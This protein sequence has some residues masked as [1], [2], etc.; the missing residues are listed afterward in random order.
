MAKIL[1]KPTEWVLKCFEITSL[2]WD[3]YIRNSARM[4]E[5][6]NRIIKNIWLVRV[7]APCIVQYVCLYSH[8]KWKSAHVSVENCKRSGSYNIHTHTYTHAHTACVLIYKTSERFV[9]ANP[10]TG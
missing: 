7:M 3:N 8:H 5:D 10:L 6:A 4:K 9:V 2:I 1:L